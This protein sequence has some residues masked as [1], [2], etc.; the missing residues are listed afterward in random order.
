MKENICV[1]C[2]KTADFKKVNQ[3]NIVTLVCKDCAIKET[4]FKLTNNDNLKCDNCDNK[5]KYMSLTQLNRIKNLCEN[6]LL[7]D[8]KAI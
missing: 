7:K 1:N 3:L 6:C 5:S 2:K 4:N 8:Y